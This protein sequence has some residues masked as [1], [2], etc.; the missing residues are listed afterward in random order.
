M[1]DDLGRLYVYDKHCTCC[2]YTSPSPVP[3]TSTGNAAPLPQDLESG[4]HARK[5]PGP[6]TLPGVLPPPAAPLI[7]DSLHFNDA[8]DAT[9][10]ANGDSAANGRPKANG[11]LAFDEEAKLVYGVVFSLRN[12]VKKLSSRYALSPR[13]GACL[14]LD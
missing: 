11:R 5:D 4:P 8:H 14:S 6:T 12:M 10:R 7:R 13:R 3:S 1:A 9:N 2:F